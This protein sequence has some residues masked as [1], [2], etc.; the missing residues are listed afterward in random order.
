[1]KNKI[2]NLLLAGVVLLAACKGSGNYETDRSSADSIAVK[3]TDSVGNQPKIVKTAE[4]GFKVKNVQQSSEKVTA[5]TT[6]FKGTIVHHQT[7]SSVNNSHDVKISDDSVMRVS[8]M[9]TN[10]EITAKVP[11]EKLDEYMN[12][13]SHMGIYVT[14]RK[15]DLEDKTLDYLSSQLKVT[16][17][18]E[19]LNQQRKGKVTIKNPAD[20]LLLKDDLID[21][22]ISNRRI[23]DAVKYS[24]VSLSFY[25]SNTILKEII[26]N[27]NPSAYNIPFF[28]RVGLAFGNG[29]YIFKEFMLILV[30][31]W[32][33]IAAGIGIWLTV[34]AY[35]KKSISKPTI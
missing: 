11:S 4:I 27:D 6:Q 20:V 31:A 25:Q 7:T 15:M 12:Q 10:C 19:F 22:Q 24:T 23:D 14:L 2:L 13:V 8:A 30:N 1:M 28:N 29:W 18:R 35:R 3:Q 16:G 32:V 5:L 9:N 33:F 17:R 21:Q 34:K 26:A